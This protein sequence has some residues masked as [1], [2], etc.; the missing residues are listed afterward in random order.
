MRSLTRRYTG[1]RNAWRIASL[2]AVVSATT[3]SVSCIGVLSSL[4]ATSPLVLLLP[5]RRK[6]RAELDYVS[7]LHHVVFALLAQ[8]SGLTRSVNR[9]QFH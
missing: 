7:V 2:Q 8:L 4:T 9:T 1:R 6:P 3:P 5:P